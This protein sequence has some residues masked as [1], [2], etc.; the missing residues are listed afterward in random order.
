MRIHPSSWHSGPASVGQGMK[1]SKDQDWVSP[2]NW[3]SLK[4][5]SWAKDTKVQFPSISPKLEIA[6][7]WHH[8]RRSLHWSRAAAWLR[9]TWQA[10][11]IKCLMTIMENLLKDLKKTGIPKELNRIRQRPATY[12][13]LVCRQHGNRLKIWRISWACMRPEEQGS[14]RSKMCKNCIIASPC[15]KK[16]KKRQIEESKKPGKELMIWYNQKLKK[17]ISTGK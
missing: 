15:L 12:E 8:N 1:S 14:R 5:D 13:D 6:R 11:V 9:W 16:K 7:S 4:P 3:Q 10:M 17:I 2:T